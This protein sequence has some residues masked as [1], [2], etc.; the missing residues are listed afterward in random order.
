MHACAWKSHSLGRRR[1]VDTQ[2]CFQ[3]RKI[4]QP[5]M[6]EPQEHSRWSQAS[7]C[8]QC[9]SHWKGEIRAISLLAFLHAKK[10]TRTKT[11]QNLNLPDSKGHVQVGVTDGVREHLLSN[12]WGV[13]GSPACHSDFAGHITIFAI[14][15]TRQ[16]INSSINRWMMH[17][18]YIIDTSM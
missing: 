15:C 12:H 11:K 9:W 16:R 1:S 3:D 5:P 13:S 18:A 8:R 4:L 17:D 7:R 2:T 6:S 10:R 14:N